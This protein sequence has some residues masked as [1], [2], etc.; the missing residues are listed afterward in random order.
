[1]MH[2]AGWQ[3]NKILRTRHHSCRYASGPPRS[4]DRPAPNVVL[5]FSRSWLIHRISS[6]YEDRR[7]GH[8]QG[9]TARRRNGW[10]STLHSAI[11]PTKALRF[12]ANFTHSA[13]DT[14]FHVSVR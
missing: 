4:R 5:C 2:H 14:N 12:S 10:N 1:L 13:D 7:F 8:H 3:E 9:F 6:R 11:F